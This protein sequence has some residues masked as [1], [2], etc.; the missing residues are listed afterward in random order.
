MDDREYRFQH[1]VDEFKRRYLVAPEIDRATGWDIFEHEDPHTTGYRIMMPGVG[2]TG[3]D[4]A[5]TRR[6]GKTVVVQDELGHHYIGEGEDDLD[7][8]LSIIKQ[9]VNGHE[10][11]EKC[12]YYGRTE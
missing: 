2:L 1:R 6:D 5:V 12:Q 9:R 3:R 11:N 8:I 10:C 4:L 7:S